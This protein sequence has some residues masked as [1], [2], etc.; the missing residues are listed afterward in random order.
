MT[1]NVSFEFSRQK[2]YD[3]M[4]FGAEI[5]FVNE[6]FEVVFEEGDFVSWLTLFIE[7]GLIDWLMVCR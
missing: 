2:W 5:R 3:A 4:S 1:E 7:S 6:T